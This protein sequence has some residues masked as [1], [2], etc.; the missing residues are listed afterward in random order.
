[1]GKARAVSILE[2]ARKYS[3]AIAVLLLLGFVFLSRSGPDGCS[4]AGAEDML[5]LFPLKAIAPEATILS[6]G[7]EV[8]LA[9]MGIPGL[10]PFLFME[11]TRGSNKMHSDLDRGVELQ[12]TQLL[13][14]ILLTKSA[15]KARHGKSKGLVLDLGMNNGWYTLLS[16]AQGFEV[17]AFEPQKFCIATVQAALAL[18]TYRYPNIGERVQIKNA[19]GA[20][21]ASVQSGATIQAEDALCD[22]GFGFSSLHGTHRQIKGMFHSS[23]ST[24]PT[25]Q[26]SRE[27][28]TAIS[29]YTTITFLKVDTEGAELGLLHDLL[30]LFKSG[31]IEH[32]VIEVIPHLWTGPSY[33]ITQAVE[34]INTILTDE[35][36]EAILLT[37]TS[38]EDQWA[39]AKGSYLTSNGLAQVKPCPGPWD[40]RG[41]AGFY[42]IKDL[43]LYF[44]KAAANRHGGNIYLRSTSVGLPAVLCN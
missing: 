37:D 18:N 30:P 32:A 25:K 42:T 23:S 9:K 38:I 16:A 5:T 34:M 40:G 11:T 7:I 19:A 39:A 28:S 44:E 22:G 24:I 41:G 26:F 21:Q 33:T 6:R 31:K 17:L 14:K 27:Y 35:K 4:T 2:K 29:K 3:P 20:D 36:Y 1:M 15:A 8:D 10:N 12:I 43:K 13:G